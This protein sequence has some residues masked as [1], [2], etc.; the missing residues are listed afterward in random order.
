MKA[1]KRSLYAALVVLAGLSAG[2]RP[3]DE[4]DAG[5]ASGPEALPGLLAFWNFQ[6]S[7]GTDPVSTGE[8]RYTLKEMNGPIQ[9]AED[10]IFGPRSL[11]LEWGQWLR[12]ERKDAPGLDL[13]GDDQT[14]T[15]VAWVQR[16][17]DRAWQYIAGVWNEGDEKYMGQPRATGPGAPA[18]QYALFMSGLWQSDYTTYERTPAEHQAMGYL[19]PFGGA[20]PE[21]PFAFDYAT[22]ATRIEKDRWYMLAYTFDGEAIR[23][24]VDGR[25]DANGNYNPFLYDGTIHDGGPDG[26]D[27]T[28]AHR[29][30]PRWPTY[31]EGMPEYKE[32]FDGK[33][34]GLAV[35][36]RALTPE[37]IAGLYQATMQP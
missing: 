15:M 7:T 31:P 34:G 13:H 5:A 9:R 4:P 26:A 30:H 12:V 16:Q 27:F 35:Y 11:D 29:D 10:G 32:G 25:L 1:M 28:V 24:Y 36:D 23:V 17:S 8:Y 33:L 2:C 20:T 14:L 37:E 6:E 22:G 19:S 18:R 3:A 21:H